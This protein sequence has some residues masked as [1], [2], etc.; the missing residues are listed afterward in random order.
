M[1]ESKDP[2]SKYLPDNICALSDS[3]YYAQYLN[4]GYCALCEVMG[5]ENDHYDDDSADGECYANCFRD[6]VKYIEKL[7]IKVN[8]PENTWVVFADNA[9]ICLTK[10]SEKAIEFME[11]H[12]IQR[13]HVF[14]L[15][16]RKD[17]WIRAT[18]SNACATTRATF[19][20]ATS[21]ELY[22]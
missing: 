11:K 20:A 12:A 4:A 16:I 21:C 15:T 13:G 22:N 9:V 19:Y 3:D 18:G 6:A 10:S 5:K 1:S 8:Q 14:N 7:Q 2:I 17:S